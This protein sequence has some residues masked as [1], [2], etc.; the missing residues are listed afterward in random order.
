MDSTGHQGSDRGTHR[1]YT[2]REELAERIAQT[3]PTDGVAEP[4]KGLHL[5][6]SSTPT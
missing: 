4:L 2:W 6:R 3:V 5:H 1:A